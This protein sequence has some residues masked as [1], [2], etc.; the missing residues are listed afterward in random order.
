MTT[1]RCPACG[2]HFSHNDTHR[3]RYCS[4]AC[5]QRRPQKMIAAE[6]EY[7]EPVD[8]LMVRWLN[9]GRSQRVVA[10]LLGV[11]VDSVQRWMRLLGIRRVVRYEAR[12]EGA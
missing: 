8:R 10:G 6:R 11:E 2:H 5:W 3:R 1:Q 4:I 9:E 12:G 7:G